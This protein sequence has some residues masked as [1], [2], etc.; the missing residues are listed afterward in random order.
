MSSGDDGRVER[1]VPIGLLSGKLGRVAGLSL[2]KKKRER[3]SVGNRSLSSVASQSSDSK[4]EERGG[5]RLTRWVEEEAAKFQDIHRIRW[6]GGRGGHDGEG[7][8]NA[9]Q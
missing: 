8:S 4:Q 9:M 6:G 1:A 5:E 7:E 2:K 3:D